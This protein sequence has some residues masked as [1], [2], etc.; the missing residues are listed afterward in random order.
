MLYWKCIQFRLAGA[1]LGYGPR[2]KYRLK[3]CSRSIVGGETRMKKTQMFSASRIT[4]LIECEP[5]KSS[6]LAH[7]KPGMPLKEPVLNN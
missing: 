3:P 6:Q 7:F 2:S 5:T 4:Y 1:P